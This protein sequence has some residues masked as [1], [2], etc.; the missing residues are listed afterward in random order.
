MAVVV[1]NVIHMAFR[2]EWTNGDPVVNVLDLL[3]TGGGIVS[4]GDAVDATLVDAVQN[5]QTQMLDVFA[6]NY[7]FIGADWVDL[8]S[9]EG[10]VG[11]QPAN[12]ADPI[13]GAITT[14][15][16]PPSVAVLV[17]KICSSRTRGRRNGRWY[18]PLATESNI[19]E[20]G[21]VAPSTITSVIAACNAFRNNVNQTFPPDE[22]NVTIGV[23]SNPVQAE[24]PPAFMA[25]TSFSVRSIVG[26]QRRRL[27]ALT[28]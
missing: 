5:W 23:V 1:P 17:N 8:D 3:V 7:T 21:I 19:D 26:T 13:N 6:N 11:F 4:R 10:R 28:S 22:R 14:A 24:L 12:P 20:N 15:S 27:G 25:I 16:S 2:G 9:E 18:I